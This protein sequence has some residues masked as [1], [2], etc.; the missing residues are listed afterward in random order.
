M[1]KAKVEVKE[2]TYKDVWDTLSKIDCSDH[3]EKKM[4]LSYLS[5][6]WAWG[7]GL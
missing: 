4:N 1:A 6:A 5:W 2:L 7:M 3:I